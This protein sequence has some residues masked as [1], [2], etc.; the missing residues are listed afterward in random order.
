MKS[1]NWKP[2]W[3]LSGQKIDGSLRI[4]KG[5][6]CLP[7]LHYCSLEEFSA[8]EFDQLSSYDDLLYVEL[9]RFP[10]T[11]VQGRFVLH[12]TW[13]SVRPFKEQMDFWPREN[14]AQ[15]TFMELELSEWHGRRESIAVLTV[16]RLCWQHS[17]SLKAP[18]DR[19]FVSLLAVIGQVQYFFHVVEWKCKYIY[20]YVS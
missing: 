20:I 7:Q 16:L 10:L 15:L 17:R 5:L 19:S 12:T 18:V 6:L 11:V 14:I 4:I 9:V 13:E 1:K 3:E 2:W 8:H